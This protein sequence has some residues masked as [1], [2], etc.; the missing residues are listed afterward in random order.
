MS[1]SDNMKWAPGVPAL[2]ITFPHMERR[3]SHLCLIMLFFSCAADFDL[4]FFCGV[5]VSVIRSRLECLN[6]LA[7]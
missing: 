7:S 4:H 5:P 3:L 1:F 2:G 6:N